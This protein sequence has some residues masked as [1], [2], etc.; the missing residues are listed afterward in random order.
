[1]ENISLLTSV[2]AKSIVVIFDIIYLPIVQLNMLCEDR[3]HRFS[4]TRMCE[5]GED[6]TRPASRIRVFGE[7]ERGS[8][9][10]LAQHA[11]RTE[12]AQ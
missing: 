2:R 8:G 6:E 4:M 5:R 10:L 11:N 12:D 7:M 3:G 9:L 1:M